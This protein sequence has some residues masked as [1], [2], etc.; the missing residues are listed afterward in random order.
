M[1]SPLQALL[2]GFHLEGRSK[3][4]VQDHTLLTYVVIANAFVCIV[5]SFTAS[6]APSSSCSGG[7]GIISDNNNSSSMH[8]N[9]VHN[10]FTLA[11]SRAFLTLLQGAWFYGIAQ[12]EYS[13][14]GKLNPESAGDLMFVPFQFCIISMTIIIAIGV[15]YYIIVIQGVRADIEGTKKSH[16]QKHIKYMSL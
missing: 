8:I 7:G 1:L 12:N 16:M 5:Q 3:I 11:M 4:A 14:M 15:L 9:H 6:S 10:S 2:F 13:S